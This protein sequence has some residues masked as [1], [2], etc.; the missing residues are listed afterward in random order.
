MSCDGGVPR[1]TVTFTKYV[2]RSGDRVLIPTLTVDASTTSGVYQCAIYEFYSK[3]IW[4]QQT[5][6]VVVA[7]KSQ[8]VLFIF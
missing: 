8:F 7:G 5:T 3:S 6:E 1:G 4:L 2:Y